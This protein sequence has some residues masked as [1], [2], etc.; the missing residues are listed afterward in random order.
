MLESF[1]QNGPL[2]SLARQYFARAFAPT[3][4]V[5]WMWLAGT[6]IAL[7]V[8]Y[9]SYNRPRSEPFWTYS[10]PWRIYTHPSAIIDYKF[11]V[12]QK[13]ITA[14]I[15]APM[16]VSALALGNWGSKV[17]VSWLGPGPAWEA[18]PASLVV[19]AAAR[20]LL[21]DI[22]HYLSHYVQIRCPSF[23][24][25]IESTMRQRY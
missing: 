14:L 25:F 10:A 17:L 8:F 1:G 3:E 18:G 5:G 21:F 12:V 23:G 2:T 22:G 20:L 7:D 19:F 13:L 6:L 24:S 11:F 9:R 15:I 4:L 16:L